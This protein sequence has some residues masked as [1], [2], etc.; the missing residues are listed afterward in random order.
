MAVHSFSTVG[1]Y[2]EEEEA[3]QKLKEYCEE[4]KIVWSRQ[5]AD[6]LTEW[7]RNNIDD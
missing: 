6:I 5:V 4:N 7:V 2:P 3:I 1:K